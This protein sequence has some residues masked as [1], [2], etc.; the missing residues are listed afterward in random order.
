MGIKNTVL[1][2]EAERTTWG[3]AAPA[4]RGFG[5]RAE[6]PPRNINQG[7]SGFAV[8]RQPVQPRICTCLL[9]PGR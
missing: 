7:R 6:P 2:G 4:R 8:S 1:K 5:G 9:L 3:V